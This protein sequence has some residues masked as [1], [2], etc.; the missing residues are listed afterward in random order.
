MTK[1]VWVATAI[2]VFAM[3]L[4][5]TSDLA[6]GPATEARVD[7]SVVDSDLNVLPALAGTQNGNPTSEELYKRVLPSIMTAER[8]S[9]P[10]DLSQ[11]RVRSFEPSRKYVERTS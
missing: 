1:A 10:F 9:S 6:L 7:A 8:F 11:Q 5:G 4:G 3:C 2:L